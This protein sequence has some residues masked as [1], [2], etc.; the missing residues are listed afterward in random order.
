MMN[1]TMGPLEAN[2]SAPYNLAQ[3]AI[4]Y[5]MKDQGSCNNCE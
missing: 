5:T 3:L 2:T 4:S 1:Y